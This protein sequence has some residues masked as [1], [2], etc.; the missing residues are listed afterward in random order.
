MTLFNTIVQ[1][2][3]KMVI[4]FALKNI[5]KN[6]FCLL[7]ALFLFFV[8]FDAQASD[9][10]QP[11]IFVQQEDSAKVQ[12]N[13]LINQYLQLM[14]NDIQSAIKTLEKALP[15]AQSHNF[16]LEQASIYYGLGNLSQKIGLYE[17]AETHLLQ[18]IE[19]LNTLGEEKHTAACYN[20]LGISKKN[21][22]KYS[23][24]MEYLLKCL[25]I[26]E[27]YGNKLEM[28]NAYSNIAVI[29]I[30]QKK[31]DRAKININRSFQLQKE[32]GDY[33]GLFTTLFNV[34]VIYQETGE[35]EKAID[36]YN[37]ALEITSKISNKTYEV[38]V[39]MNL[40]QI[41]MFK[42]QWE[43]ARQSLLDTKAL[44]KELNLKADL[45][46]VLNDLGT[47]CRKL[48]QLDTSI[49]YLNEAL[50]VIEQTRS[51]NFLK[52]IHL[53]LSKS[54]E[55]KGSFQLALQHHQQY[56]IS[57]DSLKNIE[58]NKHLVELQEKYET[59]KLEKDMLFLKKEKAQ[60]EAELKARELAQVQIE[61]ET[62][63]KDKEINILQKEKQLKEA[64]ILQR[65]IEAEKR[66]SEITLLKRD[67]ELQEAHLQ[68]QEAEVQRQTVLRNA[69]IAG[70][71][72][73]LIATVVL[74]YVYSQKLNIQKE[75]RVQQEENSKQRVG[76]LI[77]DHKIKSI[78]SHMEGQ[79]QERER[80]ARELHDGIGGNL[81]TVKLN[82]QRLNESS[83][84]KKLQNVLEAIDQT[85]QEVR[86]IS[87]DLKPPKLLQTAF[88]DL[89]QNYTT[90]IAEAY[91]L[92]IHADYYPEEELN[93]I[94]DALQVE[95]YRILQE[96]MN[97]ILKH[98]QANQVDLQLVMHENYLNL[99]VED[100]G[101]GFDITQDAKGIGL[102]NIISRVNDLKGEIHIDSSIGY[103]TTVNIDLSLSQHSEVAG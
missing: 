50:Q 19:V 41:I 45:I 103:G 98:A 83:S 65:Q 87:H 84:N 73:V 47:T 12:V 33:D 30:I 100:N 102:N 81:A 10:S 55:E 48:G 69:F 94:P 29:Y 44:L 91:R 79:Q 88:V 36:Y 60:K 58:K 23:K 54:Y 51:L 67:K 43:E 27:K 31:Y 57:S 22:G 63:Q 7:A 5:N 38:S 9:V 42:E 14:G 53:N 85:C 82:L 24:A 11:D 8:S 75:L 21:Q 16:L 4:G 66:E 18:S 99:I 46:Q 70:F 1:I 76:E 40:S 37:K 86:S 64:Q 20:I 80:I 68:K 95:I 56:S 28:S 49:M 17:Q 13:A 39:R 59:Q 62:A 77:K 71:V 32:L 34:A 3:F 6:T 93:H 90:Q 35:Y 92:E 15:I 72:L 26:S 78:Q 61:L 101:V 96:L 52:V 89:V 97:N 74:R 25:R 2:F